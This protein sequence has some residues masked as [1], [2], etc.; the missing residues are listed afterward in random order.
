MVSIMAIFEAAFA[1]GEITHRKPHGAERRGGLKQR[2]DAVHLI[3]HG[4]VDDK[5]GYQHHNPAKKKIASAL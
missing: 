3:R 1:L 4:K 5:G 2:V